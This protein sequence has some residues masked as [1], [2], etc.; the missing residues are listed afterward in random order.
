MWKRSK[1]SGYTSGRKIIS[2]RAWQGGQW[3][4]RGKAAESRDMQHT[5]KE[6]QKTASSAR[7]V[8]HEHAGRALA[9][10]ACYPTLM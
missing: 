5:H 3:A 1:S 10:V 7:C 2:L 9:A 4:V 6:V 8:P